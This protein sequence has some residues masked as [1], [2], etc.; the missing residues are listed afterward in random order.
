MK[1]PQPWHE[2]FFCI[3]SAAFQMRALSTQKIFQKGV[4][5][6]DDFENLHLMKM[7]RDTIDIYDLE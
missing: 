6:L 4:Y 7:R 2:Y 3:L 1:C 5:C